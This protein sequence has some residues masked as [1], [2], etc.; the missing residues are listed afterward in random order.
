MGE[1]EPDRRQRHLAPVQRLQVG[2]LHVAELFE[3]L[4]DE[5]FQGQPASWSEALR[6]YARD[7]MLLRMQER[8]AEEWMQAFHE[9][10]N[11]AAEPYLTTQEGI[12]QPDLLLNGDVV[13]TEHG[14]RVAV[15]ALAIWLIRRTRS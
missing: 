14:E 13:E 12:R 5:R 4:T 15:A 7:Q 11:V 6:E 9:N 1:V 8:T 10:G 2:S 3:F